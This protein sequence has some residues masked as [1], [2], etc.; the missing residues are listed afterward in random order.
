MEYDAFGASTAYYHTLQLC[1]YV[2]VIIVMRIMIMIIMMITSKKEK[3]AVGGQSDNL[4]G[5]LKY[6]TPTITSMANVNKPFTF[7]LIFHF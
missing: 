2:F 3:R 6:Q 1:R 7:L 5:H 4:Y